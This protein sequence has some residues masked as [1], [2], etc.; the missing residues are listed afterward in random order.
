MRDDG[1]EEE[2]QVHLLQVHRIQGACGNTYIRE[3]SLAELL[4]GTI[5]P[6]QITPEIAAGIAD[7]LRTGEG[8]VQQRRTEALRRLEQR[9]RTVVSKLDRGYDD[10]V[11]NAISDELWRRK[12]AEWEA[13]LRAVE[14]E[15]ARVEQPKPPVM[16]TADRILEL[17]QR[18][19][20]FTNR[21]IGPNSGDYSKSCYRTAPSIAE[22]FLLLTIRRLIYSCRGNKTGNWLGAW[23]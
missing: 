7:T 15:L 21:R 10:F 16:A 14:G 6:I 13:D 23:D 19:N 9:R 22:V 11:S 12:S 2:G 18:P 5:A 3:E 1:R 4:G 17:T 8:E 20:F